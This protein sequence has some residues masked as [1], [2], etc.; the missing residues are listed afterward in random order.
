MIYEMR[1]YN[2]KAGGAVAEFEASFGEALP[3]R[4]K[5]SKLG[6]FWHTDFGPLN[7]VIHVWPYED[8]SDREKVVAEAGKDPNWPPKNL[9]GIVDM[10]SEIL[11]PAPFN[12]PFSNQELGN[13]YE[14]R[15][16]T[17]KPGTMQEVMKRWGEAMP[18]R[19]EYSPCAGCF[20]SDLGGLNKWIHIW[21]Y[22][23][24]DDRTRIRAESLQDPHWPAPTREFQVKQ[25]NKLLIPASFSPMH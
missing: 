17:Y 6:A 9:D 4:E 20:Y 7:Q 19:E 25:E 21:P 24:L 12:R 10:T 22:K 1:T 18:Y 5:Y 14:M 13:F 15:T 23:T 16:Y 11:I 2:M 3:H 8:L